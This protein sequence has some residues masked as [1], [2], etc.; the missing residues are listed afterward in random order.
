MSYA[1]QVPTS[2]FDHFHVHRYP[3]EDEVEVIIGQDCYVF[4]EQPTLKLWLRNAGVPTRF[5]DRFVDLVWNWPLLRYDL[6]EH[7]LTVP[8]SQAHPIEDEPAAPKLFGRIHMAATDRDP[9]DP[10]QTGSFG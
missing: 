2:G 8:R 7:L 5:I 6:K 1:L 4:S 10:L 3:Y 9:F